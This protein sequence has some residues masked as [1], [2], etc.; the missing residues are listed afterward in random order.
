MRPPDTLN[1]VDEHR[2]ARRRLAAQSFG[3]S[4]G[5]SGSLVVCSTSAGTIVNGE[6][7]D[8]TWRRSGDGRHRASKRCA[9]HSRANFDR[10]RR[11]G[12]L[13][14]LPPGEQG[15]RPVGWRRRHEDGQT[16]GRG[17]MVLVYSTTKGITAMC[18]NRLAQ[19][20]AIDV[21]APVATYWP[22][23]AAGRQGARHRG[24]PAGPPGR[25]GLDR[26]LDVVRAGAGLGPRSSRP[27]SARHPRGRRAAPT[28][29]TPPP[30]A[31]WSA[32]WC[33]G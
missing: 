28:A 27:S 19:Q 24:R 3:P 16:V 31:G 9:R 11:P 17:H 8:D 5:R 32:R 21:D 15:G 2:S 12:R 7:G 33:G 25:S 6:R 13:R 4:S 14:C 26:R 30:T 10:G 22:E 23:F 18:A 29:T 1:P 20:G